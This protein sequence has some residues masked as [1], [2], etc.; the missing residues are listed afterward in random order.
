MT[1]SVNQFLQRS[2]TSWESACNI[3]SEKAQE[4]AAH[5]EED[6]AA[7]EETAVVE[8]DKKQVW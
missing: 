4:S 5:A 1:L 8:V 7:R 2:L 6:T 3:M